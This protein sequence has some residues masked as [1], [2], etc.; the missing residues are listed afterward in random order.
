MS[1]S[2]NLIIIGA[3][4]AG[5]I[6]LGELKQSIYKNYSLIGFIDDDPAKLG[7]KIE[8]IEILGNTEKIP[9]IVEKYNIDL[10]IIAIPS[11]PGK[12]ISRILDI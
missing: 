3:G 2:S 8:N 10:S 1:Q 9:E 7:T 4:K 5:R 12:T 11:A 6:L